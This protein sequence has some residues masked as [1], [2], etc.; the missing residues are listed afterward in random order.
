MLP[1]QGQ[2]IM[3]FSIKV[4]DILPLNGLKMMLKM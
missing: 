2:H 1:V 3:L 4:K